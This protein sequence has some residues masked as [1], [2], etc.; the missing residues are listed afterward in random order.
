MGVGGAAAR[1]LKVKAGQAV[2]A[3]G[4]TS[5]PVPAVRGTATEPRDSTLKMVYRGGRDS[6]LDDECAS[7]FSDD[8]GLRSGDLDH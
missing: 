3:S 5:A 7:P 4:V 6:R 1:S 2:C 8:S